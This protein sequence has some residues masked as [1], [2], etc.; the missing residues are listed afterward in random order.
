MSLQH[1]LG[2]SQ[3]A[4]NN[5]GLLRSQQTGH[6]SRWSVDVR[7]LPPD[8]LLFYTLTYV[9]LRHGQ[10]ATLKSMACSLSKWIVPVEYFSCK[11]KA[12]LNPSS[13]GTHIEVSADQ[14]ENNIYTNQG[15]RPSNACTAV[16]YDRSRL[17]DVPHVGDKSKQVIWL[18]R[19][20]VVRP[21]DE[22]QMG[23]VPYFTCLR[24]KSNKMWLVGRRKTQQVS[25]QR[26]QSQKREICPR[27]VFCNSIKQEKQWAKLK[28]TSK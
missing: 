5:V 11:S 27:K 12:Q 26:K 2:T 4:P 10:N 18:R 17:M 23:N 22:V 7:A 14:P 8:K 1:T 24:F 16:S 6:W 21:G 19:G 9:T 15:S 3:V 28:I 13:C 25:C 20:V